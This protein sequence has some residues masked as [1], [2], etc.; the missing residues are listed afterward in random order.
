MTLSSSSSSSSRPVVLD[1]S[2]SSSSSEK[3]N[4]ARDSGSLRSNEANSRLWIIFAIP[5]VGYLLNAPDCFR[6]AKL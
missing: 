2:S 6:S 3:A 4:G 5:G 1:D